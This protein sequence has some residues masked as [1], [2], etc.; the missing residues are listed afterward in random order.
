MSRLQMVRLTCA[1]SRYICVC[2]LRKTRPTD[3]YWTLVNGR[4]AE[5]LRVGV[6]LCLQLTLKR[7]PKTT[8][9]WWADRTEKAVLTGMWPSV[10]GKL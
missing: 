8:T 7:T 6:N 5:V 9:D 2:Y 3:P 4:H 1:L 10:R